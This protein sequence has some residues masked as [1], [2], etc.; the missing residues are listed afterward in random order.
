MRVRCTD[1]TRRTL[2]AN[3]QKNKNIIYRIGV[4]VQQWSIDRGKKHIRL[5][6]N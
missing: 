3:V 5:A 4:D 1:G 6:A 2:V